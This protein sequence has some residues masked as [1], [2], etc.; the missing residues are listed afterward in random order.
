[1]QPG[2]FGQGEDGLGDFVY[3]VAAYEAI[4]VNAVDGA[5][6]GV[7]QP[8]VVVDFCGCGDG[9][10]GI[11]GGVFLLD[12]DGRGEAVD[13]IN[14][15]FFNPF[16]ELAGVGG[17]RLD[18]AALALGVD[19]VEGEGAFARAGD[20]GNYGQ[21]SVGNVAAYVLEIVCPRTADEDGVI[22]NLGI[23]SSRLRAITGWV[24]RMN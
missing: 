11:S 20:A 8:H 18:V 14:V 5:A 2:A 9:R 6:A 21:L 7:E 4:A 17:E 16:Q 10:A 22:Q 3:G 23:R 1:M 13:Q 15:W 24:R 19:G 12:G